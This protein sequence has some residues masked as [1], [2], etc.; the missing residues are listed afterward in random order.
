M[1]APRHD[2]GTVPTALLQA[3]ADGTRAGIGDLATAL[4]VT[5]KQVS[6][7]A[8][9]LAARGYLERHAAGAYQLTPAG[10]TAA[11]AGERITS[12]GRG[13]VRTGRDTLRQRAW[14]AMRVRRNFTVGDLISDAARDGEDGY[15]HIQRYLWTL[16]AAGY[17]IGAGRQPGGRPTSNGARIYQLMR[18]TGPRAPVY[19]TEAGVVRDQNTGEDLPCAPR[20]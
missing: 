9:R 11:A 20:R 7:A 14:R 10:Q 8:S 15:K 2:R 12:G 1:T 16:Q 6:D 13:H 3:L 18:D 4:G 17:V 19:R 5:R